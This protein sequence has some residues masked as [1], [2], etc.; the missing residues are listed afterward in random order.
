MDPPDLHRSSQLVGGTKDPNEDQIV[1]LKPDFIFLNSEEN[2]KK[3]FQKLKSLLPNSKFV[4]SQPAS[5]EEAILEVENIEALLKEYIQKP[6]SPILW[7]KQNSLLEKQE[8]HIVANALYF[9]WNDPVMVAGESTFIQD[10]MKYLGFNN[11]C[12]QKRYPVMQDN[13]LANTKVLLFS[14]EPFAFRNRHI[15]TFLSQHSWFKGNV[16]KIDGKL[17]SWHGTTLIEFFEE[18]NSFWNK[19]DCNILESFNG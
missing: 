16:Y 1:G 13:W 7:Q 11:A 12:T 19:I 9:I 4:I 17:M 3:S 15:Q 6:Y 10:T 2:E 5:V 8:F 14:S 18:A